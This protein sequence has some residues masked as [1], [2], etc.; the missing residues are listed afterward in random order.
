MQANCALNTVVPTRP[1]PVRVFRPDSVGY[2][3]CRLFRHCQQLLS[4][5]GRSATQPVSVDKP[6]RLYI[7]L[8]R[9]DF[10]T[11]FNISEGMFGTIFA[12]RERER[13]RERETRDQYITRI[14]H[15]R[16]KYKNNFSKFIHNHSIIF[17]NAAVF[18][19][20]NLIPNAYGYKKIISNF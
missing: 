15:A 11:N 18:F 20:S 7:L 17:N 2:C 6:D 14:S 19:M 10:L 5:T 4:L 8:Y 16:A 12:E 3:V 9:F 1:R 13:E